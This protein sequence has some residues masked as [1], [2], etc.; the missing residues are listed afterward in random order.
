MEDL[1]FTRQLASNAGRIEALVRGVSGEQ[2]RWKPDYEAWSMLEVVNHLYDEEREDFR[3]RLDLILHHPEQEWPPIDPEGWAACREY[4]KRDIE[5]SLRG[6]LKER[7]D[8][9]GWL[10]SLGSPDWETVHTS[11]YGSMRAGDMLASW[12][13]HDHIHLRQLID[14]H[15]AYAIAQGKPFSPDYAGPW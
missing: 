8:S 6:F 12:V 11:Q 15:Q 1:Y 7:E 10:E 13:T 14:L 2:A 9:L 5:T 4:G 3:A